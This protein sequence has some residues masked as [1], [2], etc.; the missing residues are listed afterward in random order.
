MDYQAPLNEL[1]HL[2]V[3]IAHFVPIEYRNKL[4][5]LTKK[6]LRDRMKD[7]SEVALRSL[8]VKKQDVLLS[9]LFANFPEL[10]TN[11]QTIL[12]IQKLRPIEISALAIIMT[13]I[14]QGRFDNVSDGLGQ[15]LCK[16]TNI[17]ELIQKSEKNQHFAWNKR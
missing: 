5:L 4:R 16:N 13:F 12:D 17:T 6:A 14:Q 2:V 3:Q 15:Q 11:T 7:A 10:A 9:R 1:Q 8:F